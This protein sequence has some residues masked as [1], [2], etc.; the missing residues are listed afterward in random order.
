MCTQYLYHIHPPSP[1]P[2]LLPSPTGSTPPPPAGPVW[3][4]CSLILY[5]K[6]RRRRKRH[7]WLLQIATWGV[8]L[9]HFHV[10]MD[11]SPIW[12]ISSIFLLSTLVPFLW[13]LQ[14]LYKF[15]I[16]SYMQSTSTIL[17]S[18]TS[19]FYPLSYVTSL[20]VTFFH[21]ISVFVLGL[22]STGERKQAA[23]GLLSLANFT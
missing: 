21:R 1:F 22:Y 13:W 11:Y 4:S 15:Y 9:W 18:F 23:F 2:H 19:F 5:K 20:H 7:F 10:Y 17:I 16:H 14:M 3:S 6:R 12:F 8:S